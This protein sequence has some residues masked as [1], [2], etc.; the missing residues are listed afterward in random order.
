MKEEEEQTKVKKVDLDKMSLPPAS[1]CKSRF[2]SAWNKNVATEATHTHTKK[3]GKA[4]DG[5]I[6]IGIAGRL[7]NGK[8]N[9][10]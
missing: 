6:K 5:P 7:S 1:K 9:K 10:S 8:E 4:T 3:G 2:T